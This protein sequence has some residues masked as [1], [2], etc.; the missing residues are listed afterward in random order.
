MNTQRRYGSAGETGHE[1]RQDKG[2]P[3]KHEKLSVIHRLR[4][5]LL[6]EACLALAYL[7]INNVTSH[8]PY[9]VNVMSRWDLAVPFVPEWVWVYNL[10]VVMPMLLLVFISEA[11]LLLEVV[12]G[13]LLIF[14]VAIAAFILMPVHSTELRAV[15][16]PATTDLA[17]KNVAYYYEMDGVGNCFPSLHV[18]YSVYAGWW[19]Y[20]LMPRWLGVPYVLLGLLITISTMTVKQHFIADVVSALLVAVLV[21][22]LHH[23]RGIAFSN[24]LPKVLIRFIANDRK[25]PCS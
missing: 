12:S 7:A 22:A 8:L 19:G 14:L 23:W 10:N 3:L 2:E 16:D 1:Q 13:F 5:A 24:Y 20:K 17:L 21:Y 15:I 11:K 25:I 6:I 18:A 9:S 4:V